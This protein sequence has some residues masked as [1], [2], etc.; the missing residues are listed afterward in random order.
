MQPVRVKLICYMC[1]RTVPSL[2]ARDW[3]ERCEQEFAE[4]QARY[5]WKCI[6]VNC[7]TPV[8]CAMK[9]CC[10]KALATESKKS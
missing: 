7:S 10:L 5:Q 8:T 6:E 4:V 2:S 1:D 9:K 3:C